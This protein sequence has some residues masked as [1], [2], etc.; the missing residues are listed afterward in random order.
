MKTLELIAMVYKSPIY[1]E[2]IFN[3]L[4]RTM[5]ETKI[6][7]LDIWFKIYLN[8]PSEAV[9]NWRPNILC[10][11]IYNDPKPEDY[12][13]NRVYRCW[14]RAGFDSVADSIC[15][16]NSD[17]MFSKDW[18]A[19]LLRYHDGKNIPC[20]RLIE[21]GKLLSGKYAISKD[22][23]KYPDQLNREDWLLYAESQKKTMAPYG[24]LFMPC[25]FD[26]ARFIEAGG[27]PEGNIYHDG[28]GTL[29]GPVLESGDAWLFKKLEREYGMK[30]VTVFDSLVYHIQ[31]GEKD[32]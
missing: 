25:I 21:S 23:G 2:H 31:E 8:D 20:S 16:I 19:N 13:L 17:M 3:E 15:F 5:S 18:L 11:P 10:C 30:H 24:G 4:L 22:F 27:Y 6:E 28:A 26:T 12:Y 1:G 14:N 32:E 9:L 7:G 29:N